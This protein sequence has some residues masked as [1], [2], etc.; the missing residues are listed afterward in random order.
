MACDVSRL[1]PSP[2]EGCRR[3]TDRERRNRDQKRHGHDTGITNPSDPYRGCRDCG[4]ESQPR[5]DGDND[6]PERG[7]RADQ[8]PVRERIEG[9]FHAARR[10]SAGSL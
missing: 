9:S 10:R 6:D 4:Y 5:V 1:R 3:G 8:K 2:A 7:R